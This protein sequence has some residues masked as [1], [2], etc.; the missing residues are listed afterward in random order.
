MAHIPYIEVFRFSDDIKELQDKATVE[1]LTLTPREKQAGLGSYGLE[2][3]CEEYSDEVIRGLTASLVRWATARGVVI[4]DIKKPT[5][6]SE[7]FRLQEGSILWPGSNSTALLVPLS[8]GRAH[9]E[10][11]PRGSSNQPV[12]RKWDPRTV[13][14]LNEMGFEFRGTGSVR[15]IYILFQT[16]PCDIAPRV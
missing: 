13:L 15:F 4:K 1:V 2:K 11:L 8:N 3:A 6:R 10:L 12:A 5:F 16:G 7:A 9:I 14:H